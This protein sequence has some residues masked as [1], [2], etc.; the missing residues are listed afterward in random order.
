[1]N[2]FLT[3]V[4]LAIRGG[5]RNATLVPGSDLATVHASLVGRGWSYNESLKQFERDGWYLFLRSQGDALLA[6]WQPMKRD[7]TAL[8]FDDMELGAEI[9]DVPVSPQFTLF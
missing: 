7:S 1:M 8:M 2:E 3:N 9:E 6:Q 4:D 5:I